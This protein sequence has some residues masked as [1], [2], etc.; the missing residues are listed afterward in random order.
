MEMQKKQDF[1]YATLFDPEENVYCTNGAQEGLVMG[2][3]TAKRFEQNDDCAVTVCCITYNHEDY[4]RDALDSFLMQKTN[5]KFKVFVGEDCGPDGTADIVREYAKKYPDI[6]VPFLREQNMGAQANLIDLCNHATSPYIAF[7]EG[8]DYWV[9]EY[10]LQKQYDYM[11]SNPDLRAAFTKAEISA[12]EDWFLRSWF[13]QDKEGRMI[14]PDCEPVYYQPTK[15]ALYG[16][17]ESIWFLPPHTSTV[18]YR[19]NYDVQIPDW[20]YTGIIGDQPIFLMQLGEGKAGMLNDITAVYRRSDVGVY[21]SA[22]M[23]EHFLR[24]RLDHVRWMSGMLDWYEKNVDHYPAQQLKNRIKFESYNYLRTVLKVEDNEAI[25]NYF[26]SYPKAAQ[27]S[28][29]AYLCFFGDSRALVK[30]MTWN[31]YRKIVQRKRYRYGLHA[32][33][34]LVKTWEKIENFFKKIKKTW[35]SKFHNLHSLICYW[36]YSLVPKTKNLWVI[37]SFR[38]RGYLDNAKYFY[39]YVV[40]NHPEIDMYWLTRDDE[41]FEMLKAENKPVCKFGT[42][43]CKKILSHAEVAVVDHNIMS[44]YDNFS[45]FNNKIKVVQLWHGVGFKAMGDG[46][47]VKTVSWPG[48]QYCDDILIKP[49]DGAFTRFIKKIKYFRHAYFRELFEEYFMMVCPGQERVDMIG[50]V[51]NIPED[52]LFMAGHPRDILSYELQPDPAN[53]KILYA[54]TFRYDSGKENDLVEA[55]MDSFDEIQALMEKVNGEFIIRLH[56]HTWR[57]YQSKIKYRIKNYDRISLDEEKDIYTRLGSYNI[58]I[59]DYSSISLDFAMLD[60]PTIYYCPDI[61]WFK[62]KQ[63]G[64]NLDFENSIPGPMVFSWED[65]LGK[66]KEYIE[67]PAKDSAFR[68]E[69][70]K[71]FFDASVNGPDNSERIVEE[72]KRRIGLD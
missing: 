13:K 27:M 65:V 56:P 41:V 23:D 29:H 70:C 68:K 67:N 35:R 30:A 5:F 25:I 18:F 47:V 48:I 44:D 8:D 3:E 36:R 17:G 33:A 32:Y 28:L 71:Y 24:T 58:V 37:T 10:K 38:G 50:K 57:S 66:M 15:N 1:K 7:C 62:R 4:I 20:Y 64:F 16:S 52:R 14:H 21:M 31:G 55:C 53:P 19:W 26:K 46:K 11:Q 45:G 72:I 51:W 42:K 39:E 43:E 6:I 40:E 63:A 54:P 9:D 49:E 22:D 34:A 2:P 12:P 59:S 60:R 61:V 69:K